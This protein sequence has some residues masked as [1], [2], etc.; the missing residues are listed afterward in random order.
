MSS[1]ISAPE[2][3]VK[4]AFRF[5]WDTLG[6]FL[7][8]SE[9][10]PAALDQA[11][12]AYKQETVTFAI[13]SDKDN[14]TPTGWSGALVQNAQIGANLTGLASCKIR[15]KRIKVQSDQNLDWQ[16][17]FWKTN[18]WDDI[19]LDIDSFCGKATFDSATGE[20]IAGANQYYYDSG[21]MDVVYEDLDGT[22][23]LHAS[24]INR[25]AVAKIVGA[26]GELIG[27]FEYEPCS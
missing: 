1:S 2:G 25:S 26:T 7:R 24:L 19:D 3:Y 9:V 10:F 16:F 14:A 22:F 5:C 13:R 12:D 20:Q 18:T 21:M 15:I 8:V 11:Q 27:E 23:A 6:N 17:Y 4:D